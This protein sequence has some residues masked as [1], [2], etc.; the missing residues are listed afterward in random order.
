MHGVNLNTRSIVDYI[1]LRVCQNI[2]CTLLLLFFACS[3]SIAQQLPHREKIDT[4]TLDRLLITLYLDNN[5]SIEADILIS[6]SNI[7]YLNVP[8]LFGKLQIA[9]T[10]DNN[11]NKLT[12]IIGKQ[13]DQYAIDYDANQISIDGKTIA[14]GN[15][16]RVDFGNRYME[17][18][19]LESIFG[20]SF[21]FNPRS[22]SA[23]LSASFE[24]PFIKQ[25]RISK[26]RNNLLRLQGEQEVADTVVKR[27]YHLFRFGML[28]WALNSVQ[29]LNQP[30]FNFLSL[31]VGTELLYGQAKV[32]LNYNN[33]FKF[34]PRQLQYSWHWVDN[35]KYFIKQAHLGI[36]G[37]QGIASLFSPLIGGTFSNATTTVRKASGF[38]TLTDYADPNWTVELYVNDV[39]LDYTSTDASGL[40][41]FKVPIVYGYTVLKLKFYSPLGEERTEERVMNVP[42][43]FLSPNKFEYNATGGWLQTDMGSKYG[44]GSFNYGV[45]RFMTIGGGVEYLSSLTKTPLISF[46]R[47][48]IQPFSKLV[49]NLEYAPNIRTKGLLNY[50]FTQSAFLE[51]NY[52]LY[53]ENQVAIR[54]KP[55]EERK[56]KVT[57][58][59]K[60]NKI[61]LFTKYN[62]S[63][64]IYKSFSYN[65]FDFILSAYYKQISA[66][67]AFI[68]NQVSE[69]EPYMTTNLSLSYRL[70][71]GFVVRPTVEYN[72]RDKKLIRVRT[73]I[74][75]RIKKVYFSMSFERNIASYTNNAFLGLRYDLP[76]ARTG[77]SASMGTDRL[78]FSESAQGS[79]AFGGDNN[80]VNAGYNSSLGKGGILFYPF[81]DVNQNGIQDKGEKRL[82]LSSVK[83]TGGKAEISEKDSIVRVSDLNA[84]VN[85]DVEFSDTDLDNIAWR[86]AHKSY[87]ILVDPNQYKRIYVPI[88][89]VGEVN[90]MVYL[91]SDSTLQGQGRITI[92][93]FDSN[94]NKVAETLSESDGY[95][96]YLGLKPGNYSLMVDPRQLESLDYWSSPVFYKGA[97]SVSEDGDVRG[98]LNFVLDKRRN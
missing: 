67:A 12:G 75:K 2:L 39:L 62:F 89:I 4:V 57:V 1:T 83:V 69:N 97:I 5:L 43:T 25:A 31:G 7:I 48:A 84:F 68:F 87:Q 88:V 20:L 36:V 37:S 14:T 26:T 10:V 59:F 95:F 23:K 61:S 79:L 30:T 60:F 65:Q 38:Y 3:T 53:N 16:L 58:P 27:E 86:F 63:Q 80:Y 85:Y 42:F 81:L 40:Y 78:S 51:L 64:F 6:A 29:S 92:Q 35:E 94:G 46:A 45:N 28:D 74:E 50:Y 34:D 90:G 76:F 21:T 96:S 8:D 44:L 9:C 49:L 93:I 52:E 33:Q 18:S 24:L 55:I 54:F 32:A 13:Q 70:R 72:L 66:N 41:V 15:G 98:G 56:V 73:E 82:L 11:S 91:S 19:L 47:V 22:L 77:F 71:N 17:S